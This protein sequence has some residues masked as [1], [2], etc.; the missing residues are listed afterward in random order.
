MLADPT[1]TAAGPAEPTEGGTPMIPSGRDALDSR[2]LLV[3]VDLSVCRDYLGYAYTP[4]GWHYFVAFLREYE[5]NGHIPPENSL[6]HRYYAKF[7]PSSLWEALT[8]I[9]KHELPGD[10]AGLPDWPALPWL[11]HRLTPE[12]GNQ[13]F[14][15]FTKSSVAS[16]MIRCCDLYHKLRQEGYLPGD[17]RDGY[18][19]GYFL[20]DGRDYRFVVTA[21]QHR[22]AVLAVLGYDRFI[23]RI[24]PG[25][26]R[27]ADPAEADHWP[28]VA[29]GVYT[30]EQAIRIMRLYFQLNGLEKARRL[31]LV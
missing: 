14:G 15:T 29:A 3:E 28:Q 13:H 9:P 18:I 25:F 30:R 31:G 4:N 26:P 22:M 8:C 20:K 17:Y 10:F 27:V 11:N 23:A 19:K 12:D 2:S 24:Q 5:Q 7:R 1:K 21:G 6:L 16:H